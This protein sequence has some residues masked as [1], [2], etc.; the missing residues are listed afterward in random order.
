MPE[1]AFA[2]KERAWVLSS[3]FQEGPIEASISVDLLFE[4][5]KS[6]FQRFSLLTCHMEFLIVARLDS[7]PNRYPGIHKLSRCSFLIILA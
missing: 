3:F 1:L 5:K 4:Q 2:G 7:L 6:I